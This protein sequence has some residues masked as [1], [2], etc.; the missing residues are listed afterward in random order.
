MPTALF[1]PD[2]GTDLFFTPEDKE[3]NTLL[4]VKVWIG[5]LGAL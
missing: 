5:F 4:R 1:I 2:Q 3:D